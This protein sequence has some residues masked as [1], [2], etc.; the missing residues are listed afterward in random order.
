MRKEVI[1]I[2]IYTGNAYPNGAEPSQ[3]KA[4]DSDEGT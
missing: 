3:E 2:G 1:Y 4:E